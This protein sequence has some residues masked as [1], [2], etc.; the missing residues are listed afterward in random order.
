MVW[1][2]GQEIFLLT[3]FPTRWHSASS[4]FQKSSNCQGNFEKVFIKIVVENGE[5]S[6]SLV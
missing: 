1:D 3:L 2:G 6:T 4:Y 5:E